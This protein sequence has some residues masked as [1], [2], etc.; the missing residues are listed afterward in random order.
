[1]LLVCPAASAD[2]IK[3]GYVDL[4]SRKTALL[5]GKYFVTAERRSK[6]TNIV[7][8]DATT[9]ERLTIYR[10]ERG[11]RLISYSAG[12]NYVLLVQSRVTT[13]KGASPRVS[14]HTATLMNND[15]TAQQVVASTREY[16]QTKHFCGTGIDWGA[17]HADR[18]VLISKVKYF[19][20]DGS[21]RHPCVGEDGRPH[22]P[23]FGYRLSRLDTIT[24]TSTHHNLF[25]DPG[26][27][28]ESTNQF[29]PN[30]R[31][32]VTSSKRG[33]ELLDLVS[34][35]TVVRRPPKRFDDVT[36]L[37]V[38]DEGALAFAIYL[39]D[40]FRGDSTI[41]T[42][43]VLYSNILTSDIYSEFDFEDD[44]QQTG[45]F[46][47]HQYVTDGSAW[48]LKLIGHDIGNPERT[49]TY[50]FPTPAGS[51]AYRLDCDAENL[52]VEFRD[53]KGKSRRHLMP[54]AL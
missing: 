43:Q 28:G 24:G 34:G 30:G 54:L 48:P 17:V 20:L 18:S 49:F 5:S 14:T 9:G 7:R 36:F 3:P 6:V 52:F 51:Y 10:L 40:R 47:G 26:L 33:W 16:K 44:P 32:F 37:T 8:T 50:A 11:S 13:P 1:M 23:R 53:N 25:G 22:A 41:H 29:S 45:R 39:P 15:G 42:S 4:D 35:K 38:S 12:G 27:P 46:C 19:R 2:V 21:K 31:L